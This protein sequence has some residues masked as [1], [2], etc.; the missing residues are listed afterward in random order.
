M[1]SLYMTQPVCNNDN[2]NSSHVWST[3]VHHADFLSE[4]DRQP[5]PDENDFAFIE[6]HEP[7]HEVKRVE[8]WIKSE[9]QNAMDD[10]L[11]GN[12]LWSPK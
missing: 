9:L 12:K 7:T 8:K 5:I 3:F 1:S 11:E 2:I 10:D 6:W 4:I